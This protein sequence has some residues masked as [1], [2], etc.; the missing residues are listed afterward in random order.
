MASKARRAKLKREIELQEL[1]NRL[2]DLRWERKYIGVYATGRLVLWLLLSFT[3]LA[4]PLWIPAAIRFVR[5]LL[6]I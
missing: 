5:R 1:E 6:G 4:T 2:C 3:T